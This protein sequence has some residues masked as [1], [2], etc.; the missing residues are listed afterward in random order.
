MSAA[1]THSNETRGRGGV[2]PAR[3]FMAMIILRVIRRGGIYAARCS[4]PGYYD[5]SEKPQGTHI[6]VPY[7][8]A[9]NT[10]FS[11]NMAANKNH[12]PVGASIAR[13]LQPHRQIDLTA[14]RHGR[15]ML[16]PTTKGKIAIKFYVPRRGGVTPPYIAFYKNA[17]ARRAHHIYYL[18][19]II[20]Y[21]LF[22]FL[23]PIPAICAIINTNHYKRKYPL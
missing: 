5:I 15:A 16:A 3:S 9:G 7:K 8:P 14:K 17:P 6:C 20:S 21:L 11:R 23:F 18:L 22:Q 19:S 4:R 10:I 12:H 1:R 13:P 2:C